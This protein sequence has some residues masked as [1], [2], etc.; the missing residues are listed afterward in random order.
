MAATRSVFEGWSENRD[1]G[2]GKRKGDRRPCRQPSATCRTS[3][4]RQRSR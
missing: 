3:R 2:G 4:G 1:D